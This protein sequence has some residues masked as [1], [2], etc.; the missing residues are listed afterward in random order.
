LLR[1][2]V[3]RPSDLPVKA[4]AC[5]KVEFLRALVL[6]GYLVPRQPGGKCRISATNQS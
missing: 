4:D 3:F 6:G 1:T 2:P 5:E